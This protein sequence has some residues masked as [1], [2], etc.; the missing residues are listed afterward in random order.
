MPLLEQSG[1]VCAHGSRPS[2]GAYVAR[3]V[4]RLVGAMSNTFR[5]AAGMILMSLVVTVG[6]SACSSD[7]GSTQIDPEPWA[8][9]YASSRSPDVLY[10]PEVEGTPIRTSH[11]WRA[12]PVHVT[13]SGPSQFDISMRV[14]I[15]AGTC[16]YSAIGPFWV[17]VN[18]PHRYHGQLLVDA[19]TGRSH[20][21]IGTLDPVRFKYPPI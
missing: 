3:R 17:E 12:Y 4:M 15:R 18:L 6:V 7:P 11:C 1:W 14:L 8:A 20:P 2:M 19:T 13:N 16:L 21:L 10:I 9:I 5:R